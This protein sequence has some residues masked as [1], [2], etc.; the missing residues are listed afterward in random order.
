M[1]IHATI[2]EGILNPQPYGREYKY[3]EMQLRK[4][5][6]IVL[7]GYIMYTIL[8]KEKIRSG[9]TFR[10]LFKKGKEC[11]NMSIWVKVDS[12]C[13]YDTKIQITNK[14]AGFGI[15]TNWIIYDSYFFGTIV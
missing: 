11:K 8:I 14:K 7:E 12:I 5:F 1:L 2:S 4:M 10:T 15:S 6:V 9:N 3:I 13:S